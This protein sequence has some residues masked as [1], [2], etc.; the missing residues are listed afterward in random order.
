M[1]DTVISYLNPDEAFGRVSGDISFL[2][3]AAGV[4]LGQL[5]TPADTVRYGAIMVDDT[6][7]PLRGDAT[8]TLTVPSGLYNPGGYFSVTLY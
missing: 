8:Y 6:G 1:I 2:D 5:G 4:K 7:E 3:L